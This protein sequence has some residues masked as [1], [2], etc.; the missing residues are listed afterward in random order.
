MD[1]SEMSVLMLQLDISLSQANK[2][3][4]IALKLKIYA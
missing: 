3:P 4:D 2:K 1:T